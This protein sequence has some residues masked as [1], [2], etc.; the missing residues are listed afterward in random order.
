[1]PRTLQNSKQTITTA[2]VPAVGRGGRSLAGWQR[3]LAA[4]RQRG[5]QIERQ[6]HAVPLSLAQHLLPADM[7][8]LGSE[9]SRIGTFK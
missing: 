4:K 7:L 8:R 3:K 9:E 2:H 6:K 1:M 5:L